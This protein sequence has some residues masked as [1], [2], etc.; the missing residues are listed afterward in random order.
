MNFIELM[1]TTISISNEMKEKLKNLGRT[2][3]TYEDIIEKMYN[4]TSK[5]ILMHY[6]YDESDSI[7][8]DEARKRL[9]N[10]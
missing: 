7:T 10:G 6:L 5:N 2:G 3:D 9:H 4:I 8:I 1:A